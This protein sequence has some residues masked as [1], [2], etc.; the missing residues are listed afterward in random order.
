MNLCVVVPCY[1]E[2]NRLP[3]EKFIQF[4][5][6]NSDI[7]V[8]FVNDGSKDQT[9]DKL[10]ALSKSSS[11]LNYLD[12]ERNQGKAEAVRQG[13]NHAIKKL[14][15]DVVAYWDAD[16]ATPLESI[17]LFKQQLLVSPHLK[18][19]IGSRI[20]RLGSHI[21]RKKIRHYLGRVF[22]TV[23][24][25]VLKVGVYDTQC[26]AKMFRV[27][28]ELSASLEKPF[29]TKWVFDVEL[30]ARLLTYMDVE[31]FEG[32]TYE[33]PLPSWKD[34]GESKVKFYDFITSIRDM[35]VIYFNYASSFKSKRVIADVTKS[36]S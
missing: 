23:A 31:E 5:Q 35:V 14:S 10:K 29:L 22:A 17:L 4:V 6:A 2:F 28:K 9:I 25:I 1:N 18:I 16:L 27:T 26:G 7:Q 3:E 32:M 12:L 19:V 24:S 21:Y 34:V 13:L 8:L 30:F 20:K 36:E 11:L 33:Y 15:V